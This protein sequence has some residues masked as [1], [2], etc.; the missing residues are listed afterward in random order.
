[1]SISGECPAAPGGLA[2]GPASVDRADPRHQVARAAGGNAAA[3]ELALTA[4]EVADLNTAAA[5]LGVHG[6]RYKDL[7][8]G[9][10]GR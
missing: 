9:L 3:T 5:Q 4:D 7:H 10:V 8:M 6:N 1:M 2:A